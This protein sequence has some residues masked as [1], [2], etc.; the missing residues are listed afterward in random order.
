MATE[1]ASISEFPAAFLGRNDAMTCC[2]LGGGSVPVSEE[3]SHSSTRQWRRSPKVNS[4]E[5]SWAVRPA[6]LL[7]HLYQKGISPL[8]P[9]LCRFYPSCSQYSVEAFRTRGLWRGAILTLWRLFRCHPLSRGGF[10]PVPLPRSRKME[11]DP[12]KTF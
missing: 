8:L 7:L 3:N 4:S 9:A 2:D 1:A 12:P 11:D 10:D 6:L 5:P